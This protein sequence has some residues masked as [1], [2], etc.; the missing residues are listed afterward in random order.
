MATIEE[1]EK[2]VGGLSKPSK[3]PGHSYSLP[4]LE[5]CNVGSKLAL[6]P[7][8]PCH[9]CYACKGR[10]KFSNVSMAQSRRLTKMQTS[11]TWVS[12]M[13]EILRRKNEKH[14]RWHDSGDL[15][16]VDH[17][18][19][20]CT[21]AIGVPDCQFWLPTQEHKLVREFLKDGG[22]IP[23]NLNIR[24][25]SGLVDGRAPTTDLCTSGIYKD[26]EPRGYACPAPLQN[27]NC[28]SCR[29]CW[30]KEIKHVDYAFH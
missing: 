20:I 16:N 7:G 10:Y 22:K 19:A 11:S 26:N 30:N 9:A 8:T 13:V 18:K 23:A 17:L 6:V 24:I 29:A 21:I 2:R 1:L 12:D 15:I 5:T 14:F 4:A 3:M 25:S 27:N 28:G